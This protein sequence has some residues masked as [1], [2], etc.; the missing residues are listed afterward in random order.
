MLSDENT[1]ENQGLVKEKLNLAKS[2]L[3]ID[4]I[5]VFLCQTGMWKFGQDGSPAW[6]H[7]SEVIYK[8]YTVMKL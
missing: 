2:S 8:Y 3:K 1:E 6:A 7:S 4:T 5:S